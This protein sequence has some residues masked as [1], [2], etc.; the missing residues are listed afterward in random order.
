MANTGRIIFSCAGIYERA[1]I[2]NKKLKKGQLFAMGNQSRKSKNTKV[3]PE[4]G[5]DD[6]YDQLD[7]TGNGNDKIHF[8]TLTQCIEKKLSCGLNKGEFTRILNLVSNRS[9]TLFSAAVNCSHS[10]PGRLL[11]LRARSLKRMTIH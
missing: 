3:K 4:A 11:L 6:V 1:E 5:V 7:A 2:F 10:L 9:L 8:S